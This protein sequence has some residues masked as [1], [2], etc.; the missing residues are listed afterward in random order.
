MIAAMAMQGMLTRIDDTPQVI[1]E[2]AFR[3][4]DAL[5][6]ESEKGGKMYVLDKYKRV[7]KY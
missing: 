4:A 5:I 7:P 6:A 1:A 3:Y 2:T